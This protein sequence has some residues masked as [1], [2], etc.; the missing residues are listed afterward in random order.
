[1]LPRK[2]QNEMSSESTT[3]LSADVRRHYTLLN[4]QGGVEYALANLGSLNGSRDAQFLADMYE[5]LQFMSKTVPKLDLWVQKEATYQ[6]LMEQI[7]NKLA[8]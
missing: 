5:T 2:Q 3:L 1:M 4:K 8:S 6:A 7:K